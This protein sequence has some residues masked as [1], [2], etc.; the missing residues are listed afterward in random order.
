MRKTPSTA[1]RGR[2]LALI[3]SHSASCHQPT[4]EFQAAKFYQHLLF[5]FFSISLTELTQSLY[6]RLRKSNFE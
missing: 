2:H 3:V 4:H 5:L 6:L 1:N